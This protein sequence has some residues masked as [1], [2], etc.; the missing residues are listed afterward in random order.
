MIDKTNFL[1]KVRIGNLLRVKRS[2]LYVDKEMIAALERSGYDWPNI[3]GYPIAD[4][5]A[6]NLVGKNNLLDLD[7]VSQFIY[8]H[9]LQNAYYDQYGETIFA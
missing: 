7:Y 8:V 2:K 1:E 6:E 5:G 3:E 4:Y 9:E